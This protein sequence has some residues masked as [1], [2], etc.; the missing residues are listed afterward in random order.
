M[1]CT[2][3]HAARG[4]TP[5]DDHTSGAQSPTAIRADFYLYHSASW[6]AL[7]NGRCGTATAESVVFERAVPCRAPSA[8]PPA[9][10]GRAA[11]AMAALWLLM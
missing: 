8:C 1:P 10:A 9:Q 5:A 3:W 7:Q 11:L 6:E 4:P 2:Y